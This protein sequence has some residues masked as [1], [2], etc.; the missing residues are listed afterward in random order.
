M[1]ES[2]RK[3][4]SEIIEAVALHELHRELTTENTTLFSN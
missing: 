1:E 4:K 2:G 3:E